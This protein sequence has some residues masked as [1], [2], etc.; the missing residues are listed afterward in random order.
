MFGPLTGWSYRVTFRVARGLDGGLGDSVR[1]HIGSGRPYLGICLDVQALFLSSDEAP[2]CAGM[3][4]FPAAAVKDP[5]LVR[6]ASHD[7]PRNRLGRS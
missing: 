2:G 6:A 7:N 5:A 3:G 4:I 1:E